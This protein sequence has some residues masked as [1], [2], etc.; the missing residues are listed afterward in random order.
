MDK[1][2]LKSKAKS[3]IEEIL[4]LNDTSVD[5]KMI[6]NGIEYSIDAFDIQFQQSFDFKGEP[7]REVKG[8]L[9]SITLNSVV[10]EQLNYWMFHNKVY[11]SGSIVFASFS[12]I[13]S[14]VMT[15]N[16]VDGRCAEYSKHVGHS[17]ISL[18]LVITADEI[19]INGMFHRNDR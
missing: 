16:F 19:S 4:D 12:R 2:T 14:P 18:R 7:Q 13:A 6:L 5:A 1:D 10:D 11:Y 15:I 17:S 8:G 9:L 3:K